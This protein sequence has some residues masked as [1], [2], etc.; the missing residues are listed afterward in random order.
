MNFQDIGKQYLQLIS[1]FLEDGLSAGAFVDKFFEVRE[2]SVERQNAPKKHWDQPH[3][4]LLIGQRRAGMLDENQFARQWA[5]LFGW[6]A[7]DQRI[8]AFENELFAL[9]DAYDD[10]SSSPSRAANEVYLSDEELRS[11][12]KAALKEHQAA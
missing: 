6:S 5:K 9:C 4:R 10:S 3:D 1:A 8:L 7:A 12:I 11:A 2:R